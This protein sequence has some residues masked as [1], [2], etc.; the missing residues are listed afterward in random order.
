MLVHKWG[1]DYMKG[2][3]MSYRLEK[4]DINGKLTGVIHF[5]TT[6]QAERHLGYHKYMVDFEA[7]AIPNNK[8][9][10]T[11]WEEKCVII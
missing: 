10:G 9:Y 6:E 11:I 3:S 1:V 8:R 7:N 5:D 2:G 4:E